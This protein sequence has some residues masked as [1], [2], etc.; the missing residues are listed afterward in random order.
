VSADSILLSITVAVSA[1]TLREVIALKV[2]LAEVRTRLGMDK[3]K[4]S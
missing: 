4:P 3:D 1:W 2:S